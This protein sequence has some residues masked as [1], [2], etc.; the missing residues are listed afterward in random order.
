MRQNVLEWSKHAKM[1]MFRDS[2]AFDLHADGMLYKI[3][4]KT[5]MHTSH[6]F[7][8]TC[9]SYIMVTLVT[10]EWIGQTCLKLDVNIEKLHLVNVS[11]YC[12]IYMYEIQNIIVTFCTVVFILEYSLYRAHHCKSYVLIV[13]PGGM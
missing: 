2:V 11:Y 13:V 9:P 4:L 5:I 8:D 6:S 10:R 3:L 7:I 1:N 12:C